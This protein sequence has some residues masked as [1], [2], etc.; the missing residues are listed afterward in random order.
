MIATRKRQTA[1]IGRQGQII[2]GFQKENGRA[3]CYPVRPQCYVIWNEFDETES[4]AF[5]QCPY[6]SGMRLPEGVPVRSK[7]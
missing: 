5:W 2:A 4:E 7:S 6:G 1:C 3:G